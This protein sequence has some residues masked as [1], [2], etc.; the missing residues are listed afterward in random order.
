MKLVVKEKTNLSHDTFNYGGYFTNE[1][2][3][4][5]F[6]IRFREYL[7]I[8][9]S[10]VKT[11]IKELN[12]EELYEFVRNI[13]KIY[14]DEEDYLKMISQKYN[15]NYHQ[16]KKILTKMTFNKAENEGYGRNLKRWEQHY[17][18]V[19]TVALEDGFNLDDTI[20]YSK[21]DII[22]M[23][24]NREIIILNE[25]KKLL[26]SKPNFDEEKYSIIPSLEIDC[27]K[28]QCNVFNFIN[29]NMGLFIN[30][31]RS[32]LTEKKMLEDAKVVLMELQ[33]ELERVFWW[34]KNDTGCYSKI[35]SL[36]QEWFNNS[37]EKKE[38]LTYKKTL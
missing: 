28:N 32:N 3:F 27:Q 12:D 37:K 26:N 13:Y 21:E 30:L 25:K 5:Q 18:T 31:L 23:L 17:Q 10:L 2:N 20:A 22:K 4:N 8:I 34:I 33:D 15:N 9:D 24:L 38:Y 35:A 7:E 6:K 36:C 11:N 1:M 29:E 19:Y 16:V 14:L